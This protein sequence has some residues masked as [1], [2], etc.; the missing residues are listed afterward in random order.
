MALPRQNVL[1]KLKTKL[2]TLSPKARTR[3]RN[4]LMFVRH[5]SFFGKNASRAGKTL[6]SPGLALPIWNDSRYRFGIG[7]LRRD[8]FCGMMELRLRP[9]IRAA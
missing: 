6:R 8:P 2:E 1:P 7:R 4:L 3:E 9:P 5:P